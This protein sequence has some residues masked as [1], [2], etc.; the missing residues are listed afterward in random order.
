[1]AGP[2]GPAVPQDSSRSGGL[3]LTQSLHCSNQLPLPMLKGFAKATK[4]LH[5]QHL[6]QRCAQQHQSHPMNLFIIHRVS[7]RTGPG[8]ILCDPQNW[9]PGEQQW[10]QSHTEC[11]GQGPA[12]GI[13]PTPLHLA[14]EL[15]RV[16]RSLTALAAGLCTQRGEGTGQGRTSLAPHWPA[17]GMGQENGLCPGATLLSNS[18][19]CG[20]E[21]KIWGREGEGQKTET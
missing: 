12:L 18:Q 10:Q 3:W 21:S 1:M 7:L 6:P 13:E 2:L 19:K 20:S 15:P 16:P 17:L 8:A 5:M 4:G 11:W 9:L 14:P